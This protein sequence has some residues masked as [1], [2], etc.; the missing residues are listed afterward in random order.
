MAGGTYEKE[1]E[2]W[3]KSYKLNPLRMFNIL[4]RDKF[5]KDLAHL[6]RRDLRVATQFVTG[7]EAINYI[8]LQNPSAH[9]VKQKKKTVSHLLGQCQCLRN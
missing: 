6:N 7:H 4:W 2:N 5:A 1:R 9:F 3:A 8:A